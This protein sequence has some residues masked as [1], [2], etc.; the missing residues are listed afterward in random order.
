MNQ[1]KHWLLRPETIRKLWIGG[2]AIL[3]LTVMAEAFIKNHPYFTMESIFGF[4]AWFGLSTCVAMVLAAKV[5]GILLKRSDRYYDE[6]EKD[7]DS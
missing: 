3:A 5:L 7:Q 2:F 4:A 6:P 1:Q